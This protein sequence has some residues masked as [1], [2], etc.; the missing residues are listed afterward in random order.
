MLQKSDG[1]VRRVING[2]LQSVE[3]LDVA[4]HSSSERG[5]LRIAVHPD[6][7][8]S[9][10]VYLYYT[11]SG[12]GADTSGAS[13]PLA[14]RVFRYVWNGSVLINP[15]LILDLPA[16]PVPNHDG[17]AMT[18]GPDGKL[19]VI[20]GDLNRN[21]QLQ[22]FSTG[23]APDDTGV[24][25]GSTTM[26]VR[27]AT[28]HSLRSRSCRSTT[29]TASANASDRV[30]PSPGLLARV[31]SRYLRTVSILF[32]NFAWGWRPICAASQRGR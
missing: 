19:Y 17:G 1:R 2:A 14:N 21:G 4:V 7:P 22:N 10:F 16:T 18:F 28:I 30:S 3:V 24:I 25:F 9:P 31:F 6:F 20:I 8:T 12:T 15:Q 27:R 11:E 5:L 23:P 26:A 13:I 32:T 29:H